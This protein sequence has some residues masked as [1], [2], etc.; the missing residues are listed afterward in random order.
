MKADPVPLAALLT[1]RLAR[2]ARIEAVARDVRLVE[3][4]E[5]RLGLPPAEFVAVLADGLR[6]AQAG[7]EDLHRWSPQWELLPYAE[8]VAHECVL[9]TDDAGA[10]RLVVSDPLSDELRQW[11]DERL[12]T[13]V[14]WTLAHR[15]DLTAYLSKHEDTLRAMDS[16]LEAVTPAGKGVVDSEDLSLKAISQDSSPVV[17]LARS[18][19][20]DALKAGASD[21]HLESTATGLA[22][23]YRIDGVLTTVGSIA[24]LE[25]AEQVISRIKVLSEL[26]IAERRVPQDG[27]F[28]V[29]ARG[30]EIDFRVSIM[31]SIFGEDAVLRILDKQALT[32]QVTGLRLE[33]LG[34]DTGSMATIRRLA[35]EPYGMCQ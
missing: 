6:L 18:T 31:P 15:T 27:R 11:A 33:S 16:V 24:G 35:S 32:N 13:A 2:E 1:P 23:K 28:K 19:L 22:I 12:K 4:L 7:M 29:L 9:F 26:D 34:F 8:A 5:E 10:V 20:H 14:R 17:K 3:V 25:L 21:V 30:R